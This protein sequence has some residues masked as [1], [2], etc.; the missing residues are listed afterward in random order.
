[1]FCMCFYVVYVII[2]FGVVRDALTVKCSLN[3]IANITDGLPKKD[4]IVKDGSIYTKNDYFQIDAD[5]FG[6][7]CNVKKCVRKCCAEN[8]TF[9]RGNCTA[10]EHVSE[11]VIDVFQMTTLKGKGNF[12]YGYTLPCTKN[13]GFYPNYNPSEQFFV[14][15]DGQI[16]LLERN[17]FI[18][19]DRYCVDLYRDIVNSTGELIAYVCFDEE[20]ENRENTIGTYVMESLK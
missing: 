10:T 4:T 15:E 6:C 12:S 13:R 2:L 9:F 17:K 18:G 7:I 8:E 20:P 16:Y 19:K 11:F 3:A 5:I 14:Q 1:M